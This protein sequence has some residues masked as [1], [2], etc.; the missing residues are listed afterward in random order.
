MEEIERLSGILKKASASLSS[1]SAEDAA[2]QSAPEQWSKKQE[3]GHLVDSACNNHQ[4]I[5]RAQVEEEPSLPDYDGDRWVMLHDYQAMKWQQI[6][7]RWQI[8]NE[9]LLR[10]ASKISSQ[11]AERRLT[12]GEKSMTLGFLVKDYVDHML[13]HL[14]HIG[15]DFS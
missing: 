1:I 4:L 2:Y 13:H 9:Q 8:M 14:R 7:E 12:V 15:V 5:V 6:V 3:L 11:T 10:A